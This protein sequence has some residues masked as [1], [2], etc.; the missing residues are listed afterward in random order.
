MKSVC[1][2]FGIILGVIMMISLFGCKKPADENVNNEPMADLSQIEFTEEDLLNSAIGDN[3][4][5]DY[6]EAIVATVGGN[7]SEE[8]VLYSCDYSGYLILVKYTKDDGGPESS[9]AC[10]VP[11]TTLDDCMKLVK[12]YKMTKW[13]DEVGMNGKIYVV[14][15][16]VD[17]EFYRITSEAMPEDGE[18][19][20]YEIRS[21]L[22]AAYKD[23]ITK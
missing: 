15:V 1:K 4:V 2:L 16:T 8:F 10:L 17:G 22:A 7:D 12:K 18:K 11:A 14:R 9:H 23:G 19:A 5:F 13:K 20:F 21:V 3:I 6:Y